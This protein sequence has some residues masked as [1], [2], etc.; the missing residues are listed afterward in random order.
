MSVEAA[1]TALC[2]PMFPVTAVVPVAVPVAVPAAA[3]AAA[4][5]VD[6]CARLLA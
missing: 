5:A 1:K 3:A 6:C 2:A 4:V